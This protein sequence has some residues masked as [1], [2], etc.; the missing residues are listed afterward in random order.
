MSER[1]DHARSLSLDAAQRAALGRQALDWVLAHFDGE[2]TR[3]INP[4]ASAHELEHALATALPVEGQDL[5]AVLDEFSRHV[6]TG[7]RAN[8]HPRMFG[9]VQSSASFAGVLA[10]FLASALNQN[11]TSWR[12][13]PSATTIERQ[14]IEWIARIVGFD[15]GSEGLFVSGGSMANLVGMAAALTTCHP[16][17]TQEGVRALPGEPVVYASSLVHLSISK[18]AGILGLGRRALRHVRVDPAFRMVP[19]ALDESLRADREAGRVP[20]CVVVNAGDV[21]TGAVDPMREIAAVCRRHGVWLHADAAYGGF[22]MLSSSGRDHLAGLSLAD[23]VAL[24]PHKWLF[25]P[26]DVG[27]VLV[28]DPAALAR[29]FGY[30]AEY[31]DVIATPAMSD[32]AFWNYGPELTRRFRALKVWMTLRCYGTR[33]LGEAIE[34]NITLAR[35]LGDM[36]D[37]DPDLERLAPVPLSIVC[38]RYLRQ[39]DRTRLQHPDE[40]Q[41]RQAQDEVNRLNRELM[42]AVQT[43]GEAYLSNTMIGDAF[44]LRACIVNYRTTEADLE[45]LLDDVKAAAHR[46]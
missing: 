24:D 46:M 44:A 5:G 22:A 15:T 39:A 28:R 23:S 8:G 6:V 12:S 11:V 36:V 43:G 30:S 25:A 41:R 37:R 26:L 38:F 29:A 42:V 35:R 4:V 3:P 17:V 19:Q 33:A 1:A 2:S 32:Y 40:R 7:A 45:R 13:A 21:N 31:V 9:Y 20:V 14:T 34:R 16:A 10:D 27:C 18:A